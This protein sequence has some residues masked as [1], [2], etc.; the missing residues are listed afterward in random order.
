MKMDENNIA[1]IRH[2]RDGRKSLR[3]I[4]KELGVS[5]NTVRGRVRSLMDE[6]VL[7]ITG[8]VDPEALPGHR[9]A[10][11]GVKLG[12]MNLISKGEE[13]SKIK[14]V[15]SVSVVTGRFDLMLTVLFNEEFRLLDFYADEVSKIKDVQSVETFIVYKGYNLMVP[16]LL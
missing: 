8:L 7:A 15:V 12:T 1:I 10:I 5:E 2:L 6:G 13:F 3:E 14:G 4:A 9:V 16:Y 11:I